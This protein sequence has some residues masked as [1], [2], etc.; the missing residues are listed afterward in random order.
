MIN[1]PPGTAVKTAIDVATVDFVALV[2][3]LQKKSFNGY[4][5]VSVMGT[6]GIE[7]GTFVFDEGKI[8]ASLYEYF[9]YDKTMQGELAFPRVMNASGAKKGV[10][11]IFQLTAQQVQLFL[12][13][14]EN[15][16]FVP[17]EKDLRNLKAS[18]FSPFFEE[19]VKEEEK[20][21]TKTDLIKKLKLEDLKKE[22]ERISEELE[23]V[24]SEAG[25]EEDL[26][27]ALEKSG[28]A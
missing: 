3:E 11:D 9:K 10:I 1:L 12:A 7:E 18:E 17:A 25:D 2:T 5:C 16:I 14:N 21:E 19:Q 26:L 4:V 22:D 8:A 15:A 6:N 24:Q 20:R 13:F 28:Q 27:G 23:A